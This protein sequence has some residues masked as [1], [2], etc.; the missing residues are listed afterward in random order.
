MHRNHLLAL[1]REYAS[2]H[3]DEQVAVSRMVAFVRAHANCFLRSCVPGHVTGSAWLVSQDGQRVLLTHHRKLNRWL[4]PG[5]H[6]DGDSRVERVALR[7]AE[8]ESGLSGLRLLPGGVFDVDIHTIPARPSEP[9]HLH[10][11]VRFVI[12]AGVDEGYRVSEESHDLA[13]V[14]V[15]SL[16]ASDVEPS[17]ARMARKWL[18]CHSATVV[19][20][21][22]K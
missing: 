22:G 12:R 8:E 20:H 16:L 6:A 19:A 10:Y 15:T 18:E 14:P 1:L 7:E 9:A 3:P 4:Q 13:W 2:R 17:M 11:D 5:G 21:I